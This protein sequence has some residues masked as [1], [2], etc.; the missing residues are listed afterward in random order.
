[1]LAQVQHFQRKILG[2]QRSKQYQRTEEIQTRGTAQLHA[3]IAC[4]KSSKN[5][6][7]LKSTIRIYVRIKI[8]T[9]K[10]EKY[11]GDG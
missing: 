1:M 7:D 9:I 3:E 4:P 10:A 8:P 5:R 6:F 2:R 11:E